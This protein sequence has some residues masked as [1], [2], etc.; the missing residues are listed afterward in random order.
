MIEAC[1]YTEETDMFYNLLNE[2]KTYIISG[3]EVKDANKKFTTIPHDKRLIVNKKSTF[4]Q[5]DSQIK[6][7][8]QNITS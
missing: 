3:I 5:V 7:D 8:W 4:K 1:F 2:T 6:I